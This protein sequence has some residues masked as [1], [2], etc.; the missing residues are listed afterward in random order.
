MLIRHVALP[1]GENWAHS[2]GL[3]YSVPQI[4]ALVQH[5]IYVM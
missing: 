2:S 5:I 1:L 4:L 3:N